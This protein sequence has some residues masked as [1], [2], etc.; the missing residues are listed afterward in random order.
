MRGDL[1]A[2]AEMYTVY[3]KEVDHYYTGA[4]HKGGS[5]HQ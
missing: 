5:F 3:S 4:D 2:Q 1:L